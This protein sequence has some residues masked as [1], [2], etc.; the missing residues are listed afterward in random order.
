MITI[1][2]RTKIIDIQPKVSPYLYGS[3]LSFLS[4]VTA[5]RSPSSSFSFLF[6]GFPQRTHNF[7][8]VL[9]FQRLS[10]LSLSRL[11]QFFLSSPSL[12]MY[13]YSQRNKL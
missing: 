9:V 3:L 13:F 10:T 1:I 5:P 11:S 6:N 7:L 2:L 12:L 4:H 8:M